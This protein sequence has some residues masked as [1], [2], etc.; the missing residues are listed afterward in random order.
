MKEIEKGLTEDFTDFSPIGNGVRYSEFIDVIR[1]LLC[2]FI[3]KLGVKSTPFG[4]DHLKLL[5]EAFI[6]NKVNKH[7]RLSSDLVY[8]IFT[9]DE[10]H[11]LDTTRKKAI[12]ID[13]RIT[14]YRDY[15]GKTDPLSFSLQATRCFIANF[16]QINCMSES[17]HLI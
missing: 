12:G 1:E 14:L 13:L 6:E 9:F 11:Y 16:G 7:S 2:E 5:N 4:E 8:E 3:F 17:K 10:F 15:L